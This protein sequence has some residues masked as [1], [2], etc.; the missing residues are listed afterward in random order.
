MERCYSNE[1]A[2][3]Y[4]VASGVCNNVHVDAIFSITCYIS[5]RRSF[6]MV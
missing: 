3:A 5:L 4:R 1:G 2:E 6:K